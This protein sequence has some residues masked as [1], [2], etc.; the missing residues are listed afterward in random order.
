MKTNIRLL[1]IIFILI[2]I[3]LIGSGYFR[4][5]DLTKEK[6]YSLSE[7]SIA[8]VRGLSSIRQS[9]QAQPVP[10]YISI[11][12]EGDFAPNIRKFQDAIRTTLTEMRQYSRGFLEYEFID[13]SKNNELL[14]SFRQKGLTPIPVRVRTSATEVSTKGMYPYALVRYRDREKYVD[15]LKGAAFPGGNINFVK[16]E[17]DLEYKL[18]EAMRTLTQEQG[19]IVGILQGHGETYVRDKSGQGNQE[20]AQLI[21]MI[22]NASYNVFIVDRSLEEGLSISPDIDVLLIMQPTQAFSERDKYEIDQYLIRGGSVFWMMNQEKVDLEL[23]RNRATFTEL[24]SLNLDDMFMK[25][26]VKLN[27]DLVQDLNAEKTEAFQE[28]ASGGQIT[29]HHWP[30]YPML[31][32]FPD[33]AVNRNIDAILLRYASSIDTFETEGDIKKSV[34][35]T[36]SP[37]SRTLPNRQFIDFVSYLNDPPPDALFN[38]G[39]QITGLMLEGIFTSLFNHREIP[40]DSLSPN[41][42][43]AKFGAQNNPTATGKM[44]IITDGEFYLGKKFRGKRGLLPYD[45]ANL[46]LN[47]IDYLAGDDALTQI[48]SKE[49]VIRNLDKKK[50]NAHS[51]TIRTMNLILPVLLIVLFGIIRYY[52]R[53][54]KNSKR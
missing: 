8:T 2:F 10:M 39:P 12:V 31:L 52:I 45:N 16:A 53:K 22:Q 13:P 34:F 54:M 15:L 40:T 33:H 29:S 1:I 17:A 44:A 7:V 41:P 25:Y 49:V 50:V 37:R 26:G 36:T 24:R 48:R 18:V 3:N 51:Q 27:Y 21:T 11:F 6:R 46:I 30:F 4:R 9:D 23:Y 14:K 28:T 47:V 20:L 5:I 42:P 19:G 35:L 32:Q 38:K 43:T